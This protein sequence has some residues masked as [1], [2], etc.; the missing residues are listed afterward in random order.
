[1]PTALPGA[2]GSAQPKLH[3]GS[4][5]WSWTRRVTGSLW[6]FLGASSTSLSA[7][8]PGMGLVRGAAWLLRTHTVDGIDR[9]AVWI[10]GDL[11]GLTWM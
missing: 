5:G 7:A 8:V 3:G 6:P 10:S 2:E 1:M 11:V 4:Q 9:E